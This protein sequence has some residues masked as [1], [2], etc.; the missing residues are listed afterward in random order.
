MMLA[1]VWVC[2][3]ASSQPPSVAQLAGNWLASGP[4]VDM[5]AI[6]NFIGSIGKDSSKLPPGSLFLVN[7][8]SSLPS[9]YC[10]SHL[11]APRR[12]PPVCRPQ[13]PT[14]TTCCR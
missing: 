3:I 6:N 1:P 10:H 12:P 8:H 13:V 4:E 9:N 11:V 14:L 5:P 2:L 7:S